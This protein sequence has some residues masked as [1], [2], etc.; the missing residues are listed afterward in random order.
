[1]DCFVA[2][3]PR[4]DGGSIYALW[5]NSMTDIERVAIASLS[6]RDVEELR[7]RWDAGKT[8]GLAGEINMRDLIAD[9]KTKKG[10]WGG[11]EAKP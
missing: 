3:A 1:M 2:Y 9:E 4:N 7:R 10:P 6:A 11:L 8:S 5:S